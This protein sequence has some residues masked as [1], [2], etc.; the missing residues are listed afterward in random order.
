MGTEYKSAFIRPQSEERLAHRHIPWN[1][2]MEQGW[3]RVFFLDRNLRR[4]ADHSGRCGRLVFFLNAV[5]PS[6]RGPSAGTPN[7]TT[8]GMM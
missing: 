3:S 7:G 5:V 6:E 2:D 1:L 8:N 4:E